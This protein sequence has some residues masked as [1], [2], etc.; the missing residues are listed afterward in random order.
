MPYNA[1]PAQPLKRGR[2]R[3]HPVTPTA[4]KHAQG[5]PPSTTKSG[6]IGHP[7]TT[8]SGGIG[9]P[10]IAQAPAERQTRTRK[11]FAMLP[12]F[13]LAGRPVDDDIRH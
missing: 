9:R 13:C 1:S 12:S 6:G 8:K 7:S 4:A 3:K 11:V 10:S 5:C 2:P